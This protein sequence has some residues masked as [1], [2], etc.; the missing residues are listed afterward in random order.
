[1]THYVCKG[2]CEGT[3]DEPGSCGDEGCTM[4]GQELERCECADGAHGTTD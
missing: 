2:S 3:S 4:F 1:M